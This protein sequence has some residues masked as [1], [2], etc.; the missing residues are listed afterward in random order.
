MADLKTFQLQHKYLSLLECEKILGITHTVEDD[1]PAVEK[2][3]LPDKIPQKLPVQPKVI[4]LTR[5]QLEP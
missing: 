3:V 1:L 4:K 2:I 5:M